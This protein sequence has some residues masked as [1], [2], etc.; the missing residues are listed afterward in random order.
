MAGELITGD[1]QIQWAGQLW[2]DGTDYSVVEIPGW[3]DLP[4]VDSGSSL[5][6]QQIGALP[7]QLLA[8]A[9]SITCTMQVT[10]DPANWPA[11]RRALMTATTI[12]Q[13]EQPLV[14]QL[15][16]QKLLVN[17]RITRRAVATTTAGVLGNPLV[18]LLWEASDPR[19]YD[20]AEQSAS[21]V[22]PTVETGLSFG[23]PTETG[24]SFGTPESGLNFGT[25]GATGDLLVV[26]AGDTAAH[27][28]IELRGPV[29]TPT[30]TLGSVRLEYA[31]TLGATDV[32][33]VDTWAGTVTLGG[34]SRISTATNRSVPEG[35]FTIPPGQ[36]VINFRADPSSTDPA[37]QATVRWRSAYM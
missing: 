27:P 13:D 15:A 7:G 32:L 16:G 6:A 37:A 31:I 4:G 21:A 36:S 33:V 17:A 12:R 2:G 10:A 23:T 20:V 26:N 22:L 1:L 11:I 30:V 18:T 24:L 3:E 35:L 29:V 9:R 19:R 5:R 28:V 25:P 8:Q 34:Q 14:V